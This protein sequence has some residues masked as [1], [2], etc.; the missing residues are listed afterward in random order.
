MDQQQHSSSLTK[1][2]RRRIKR[3]S[4][5]RA[6]AQKLRKEQTKKIIMWFGWAGVFIGIFIGIGFLFSRRGVLPPLTA[7][8]H[9]EQSPASHV[10]D[11][12]MNISVFKHMLEHA[13]G[14]GPPGVVISY[15]CEDFSCGSELI[16]QLAAFAEAYPQN[17]YVAPYPN[18]SAKIV[19]TKSG[20]RE[21]LEQFDEKKIREF[22]EGQ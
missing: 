14:S 1:R 9:I 5:K 16:S 21:K 6:F 13:D 22:I 4:H 3:E 15:N 11:R 8:G 12:P 7:Q 19:L 18:M 17:V 10:L 20:R 2:E